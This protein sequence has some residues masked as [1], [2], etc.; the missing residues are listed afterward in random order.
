M[1]WKCARTGL[2]PACA[3]RTCRHH[4]SSDLRASRANRFSDH[5]AGA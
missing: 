5:Q 4:V 2:A 3:H 1:L